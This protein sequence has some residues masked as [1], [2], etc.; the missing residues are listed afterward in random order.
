MLFFPRRGL[1]PTAPLAQPSRLHACPRMFR[2]KLRRLQRSR[3]HSDFIHC[4]H[5]IN[6]PKYSIACRFCVT[7]SL[8][9]LWRPDDSQHFSQYKTRRNRAEGV[10]ILGHGQVI[11]LDPA[12]ARWNENILIPV[13][14]SFDDIVLQS[15]KTL[16]KTLVGIPGISGRQ[17]KCEKKLT[18]QKC[19]LKQHT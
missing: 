2:L 17:V 7:N 18:Q 14:D 1:G 5:S 13:A 12:V 4:S 10:A 11:A 9:S 8:P 6:S 19:L 15:D 3:L 16:Y